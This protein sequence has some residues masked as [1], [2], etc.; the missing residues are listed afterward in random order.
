G[1]VTLADLFHH[2]VYRAAQFIRRRLVELAHAHIAVGGIQNLVT[3]ARDMN[4]LPLDL[5][6]QRFSHLFPLDRQCHTGTGNAAHA[7]DR[8][9]KAIRIDG[10]AVD[11]ADRIAAQDSRTLRRRVV[12]RRNHTDSPLQGTYLYADARVIASGA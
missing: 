12:D 2:L 10:Y 5:E 11:C 7:F 8:L 9:V 1:A 4:A 3:H 6:F